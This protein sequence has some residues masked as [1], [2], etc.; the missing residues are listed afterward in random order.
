M[1]MNMTSSTISS[2]N[3]YFDIEA[4]LEMF[5]DFIIYI[6]IGGRSGGK[7]YGSL[8]YMLLHRKKFVFVK[9]CI[10]DVKILCAGNT[11]GAKGGNEHSVDLSP[12]APLNRDFEKNIR[13]FSIPN[14][15]ALGAFFP[16]DKDN[17]PEADAIGYIAAL[18]GV[19]KFKGFDLS[20]CH[21]Y[22]NGGVIWAK[23]D[24][25][26][27]L[28]FKDWFERWENSRSPGNH[29][30]QFSLNAVQKDR[31]LITELDG[32]WNCQ[33]TSCYASL[34]YLRNVKVMHYLS[35]QPDGL[36]RLNNAELMCGELSDE[37]IGKII[38]RPERLFNPF[39][40]FAD[41][42]DEYKL[43][44]TSHYSFIARIYKRHPK[45][46]RF[47]EKVLSKFRA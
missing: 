39:H 12:M 3:Y 5:P 46:F 19:H 35:V 28:F 8:K 22:F 34:S 37:E 1:K 14:V 20:E 24:E 41:S 10:E 31:K 15:P 26:A 47:W 25:P 16:C 6:A 40:M 45:L 11:Y 33:F 4:L 23:D 27:R 2:D 32:S 30:D 44:L 9:R 17:V 29:H 36:Y 43:T 38:E 7:T 18:N 42:S 21:Y 13:A